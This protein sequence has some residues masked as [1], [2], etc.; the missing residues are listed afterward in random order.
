MRSG[1]KEFVFVDKGNHHFEI[2]LVNTANSSNGKIEISSD[3]VDLLKQNII[4]AN[5]Y[6]ALMKMQNKE[7]E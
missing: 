5:A 4:T 1:D 2:T 3:E 6:A 7:E